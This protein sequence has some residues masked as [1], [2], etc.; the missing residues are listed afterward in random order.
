MKKVK[1]A[2]AECMDLMGKYADPGVL[3]IAIHDGKVPS[4]DEVISIMYNSAWDYLEF[5]LL[6]KEAKHQ[7]IN[8]LHGLKVHCHYVIKRNWYKRDYDIPENEYQN[9]DLALVDWI[10]DNV[11]REARK[12]ADNGRKNKASKREDI[13]WDNVSAAVNSVNKK[14]LANP[15]EY[16]GQGYDLTFNMIAD[17]LI[18]MVDTS[19]SGFDRWLDDKNR[20]RKAV[21]KLLSTEAHKI[22]KNIK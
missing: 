18:K 2:H 8:T 21:Y 12:D 11:F 7:T 6:N 17:E 20:T 16:I 15:E 5:M 1:S 13:T 9:L 10:A 19:K 14:V 4:P 22:I 3:N